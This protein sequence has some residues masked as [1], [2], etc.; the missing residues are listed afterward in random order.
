[1]ALLPTVELATDEQKASYGFGLQFA[2]QLRRNSFDGLDLDAV[3]A[4]IQHWFNHRQA[5]LSDE[6]LN[7][8]YQVIQDRQKAKT[9]ELG[10]KRGALVDQFMAANAAREEVTTTESG[11]QYVRL[12]YR[13]DGGGWLQYGGNHTSDT[14]RFDVGAA[15]G[16]GYYEFYTVATDNANNVEA[17]PATPPARTNTAAATSRVERRRSRKATTRWRAST[18]KVSTIAEAPPSVD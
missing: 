17:T 1:M 15:G 10:E 3:V 16:E 9:A 5:A 7:P 8:S 2:E 18:R 13:K 14:V 6:E 11:L 12:Y 4:G